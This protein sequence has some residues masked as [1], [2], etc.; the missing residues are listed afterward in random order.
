MSNTVD[1]RV[2]EM[3]MDNNQFERAA[4]TTLGTLGKLQKALNIKS[5]TDGLEEVQRAYDNM[6]FQSAISGIQSLADHFSVFGVIGD[7]VCRRIGDAIANLGFQM[8]RTVKDLTVGQISA[9]FGKF[10]E[11]TRN[12]ATLMAQNK[13]GL[14]TVEGELERL[15][16]FTDETSYNFTDMVSNIGKFTASGK[17]LKES[18]DAME[19]IATWTAL[20]GQNAQTA[21]R[22]MYQISQAMGAGVMRKEDYKSIQ[23]AAMDTEE[24][25]Q[26]ALDAGVA[27]GTLRK[28]ADGTY[29]SIAKGAKSSTFSISQFAEHLTQEQWMTSDVMMQVFREYSSAVDQIYEYA[30]EHDIT[31]SEAIAEL[32]DNVDA[33]GLKA[34][35][36]AQEARSWGDVMDSVKDAVST[37]WMQTF[38]L[39]FGNYKEATELWTAL[40]NQLY[41][42]FMTGTEGRNELLQGWRDL[43][44][45]DDFVQ[46]LLNMVQL[47]QDVIDNVSKA[48][49]DIFPAT[50][51]E[52]LAGFTKKFREFTEILTSASAKEAVDLISGKNLDVS[53]FTEGT[54]ILQDI[55]KL[56]GVWENIRRVLKGVFAVFDIGKTA[57]SSFI[58]AITPL[59]GVTVD[60][61]K[62]ILGIAANLGD[63]LVVLDESI[64]KNDTFGKTFKMISDVLTKP[65]EMI[66]NL[67]TWAGNLANNITKI[68]GG[69]FAT[70]FDGIKKVGQ[71]GVTGVFTMLGNAISKFCDMVMKSVPIVQKAL[72]PFRASLQKVFDRIAD[73][74]SKG[75]ITTLVTIFNGLLTG[76][77]LKNLVSFTGG[78][79]EFAG[80]LKGLDNIKNPI[81]L[82]KGVVGVFKGEGGGGFGE[83]VNPIKELAKAI[84]I[85]AGALFV[86]SLIDP[87]SLPGIL[88]ALELMMK[89]IKKLT[90]TLS[91]ISPDS[92]KK[93]VG[94][95]VATGSIVG[96]AVSLV[97]MAGA[98]RMLASLEPDKLMYGLVGVAALLT[99]L[100]AITKKLS[101]FKSAEKKI[102]GGLIGL[103]LSLL[104]LVQ[105]VKQLGEMDPNALGRG[106]VGVIVILG[107][108]ALVFD[109]LSSM[110]VSGNGKT[111]STKLSSGFVGLAAALLIISYAVDK[112]GNMDPEALARGIVG[113]SVVL[114]ALMGFIKVANGAKGMV[115]AATGML[116]VSAA[117]LIFSSAIA[118]LGKM[119]MTELGTG[120]LGLSVAIIGISTALAI[121]SSNALGAMGAATALLIV[122]GAMA[123]LVPTIA[124]LGSMPMEN[125]GKALLSMALSFVILGTAAAVLTPV[126]PAMLGLAGA[127]ALFGVAALALGAGIT[128]VSAGFASLAGATD[129]AVKFIT[130]ALQALVI[131]I[132][133][134]VSTLVVSV[135]DGVMQLINGVLAA[136][137]TNGPSIIAQVLILLAGLLNIIALYVPNL[138]QAAIN[139]MAA[140]IDGLGRGI[141]ENTDKLMTA[142]DNLIKGIIYFALS[143]LQNLVSMIPLVGDDLASGIEDL[144]GKIK[145][146]MGDI[147]MT[148]EGREMT[149]SMT[150]GAKEGAETLNQE[151]MGRAEQLVSNLDT[152]DE[153]FWEKGRDWLTGMAKKYADGLPEFNASIDTVTEG[154]IG[155]LEGSYDGWYNTGGY[156]MGGTT[157]GVADNAEGLYTTVDSIADEANRRFRERLQIESPSKVFAESG[158]FIPLGL[159]AGVKSFSK[160]AIDSV[161]DLADSVSE[162]AF[163]A[164][165]YI[166]SDLGLGSDTPIIRP[167]LD[168]TDVTTGARGINAMFDNERIALAAQSF[169]SMRQD[170]KLDQLI[171]AT[172][173]IIRELQNG[174]DLYL[175]ETILAGRINRR[176]GTL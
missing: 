110:K 132:P 116:I 107:A 15:N 12:T 80:K 174:S 125:L 65:F 141:V 67:A 160:V 43:G 161:V 59:F 137:A 168:V 45:R 148:D 68:D 7:Q 48:F 163:E 146:G 37:G 136:L 13:W 46:G 4:N 69:K 25:R 111:A 19:G 36:A 70:L 172:S 27:L 75:D 92:F 105:S 60:A 79:D 129:A 128:M 85:I 3:R 153:S 53:A 96:I 130:E 66:K 149:S 115:G 49:R 73:I 74:V 42:V 21:S 2:V 33:F 40:A 133:L 175:D 156:L 122:A 155:T 171:D 23:N 58:H 138:V 166:N 35:K 57:I 145:D 10:D 139:L 47:L 144:K 165:Q 114:L 86:L 167:I 97:I 109:R 44:G 99:M 84:L 41:D 9:G 100:G 52:Q 54:T 90:E 118:K 32:G 76:K 157:Q 135:V 154:G 56:S 126:I 147:D 131:M 102:V 30:S 127:M 120:L 63:W 77:M 95:A 158:K 113:V 78:L 24:F 119:K 14:E 22:A 87:A 98:L 71:N 103:S 28:N 18:V 140:F 89:V 61:S 142:V 1:Q 39:I 26:K 173:R 151:V 124:L 150:E 88:I 8:T 51:A 93:G 117:M 162:S 31:A 5:S 112:M 20:S 164:L 81:D 152:K 82:L 123:V 62:G 143:A 176:L 50:S 64:K 11:L 159:A 6:D 94:L 108:L 91:S 169:E 104:I 17:D 38:K 101:T 106:L 83:A 55:N 170:D 134:I 121:M 29:T 16:W 72:E 34:F